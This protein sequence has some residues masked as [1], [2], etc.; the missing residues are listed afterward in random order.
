MDEMAQREAEQAAV[1]ES[2]PE[3]IDLG[4]RVTDLLSLDWAL[5]QV[6]GL[7]RQTAEN[8]EMADRA[9][10]RIAAW[11]ATQNEQLARRAAFFKSRVEEF[12]RDNRPG[13]LVG[14]KKSRSFPH[15]VVQFRS[16]GGGLV[17]VDKDAALEWARSQPV[18]LGLVR[19]KE[20]LAVKEFRAH[21]EP[22]G[23]V[24]PGCE[25]ADETETV[26]VTAA[27]DALALTEER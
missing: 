10:I 24:P 13:L 26:V 5:E 16:K 22:N 20:E 19:I 23:V 12:A 14:K 25:W 11:E 15:G 8:K 17:V 4:W 3:G 7:E 1:Q 2:E 6:A 9:R 21:C 27:G 18:E